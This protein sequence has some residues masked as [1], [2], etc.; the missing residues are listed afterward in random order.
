M[1]FLNLVVLAVRGQAVICESIRFL[2]SPW[3]LRLRSLPRG[4][5]RGLSP[6]VCD[7]ALSEPAAATHMSSS[8]PDASSRPYQSSGLHNLRPLRRH[9]PHVNTRLGCCCRLRVQRG[10]ICRGRAKLPGYQART[11][12]CTCHCGSHKH[13][14]GNGA[15][16]SHS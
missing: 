12:H 10:H 6:H 4:L 2:E 16:K 15:S 9:I 1:L 7:A 3:T 11:S 14:L 5:K 8:D 13:L